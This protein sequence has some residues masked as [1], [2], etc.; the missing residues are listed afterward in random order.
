MIIK[1]YK[2]GMHPNSRNGFQKGH[3]DLV[4]RNLITLSNNSN[5]KVNFNREYWTNYFKVKL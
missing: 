3:P 5:S 4:P 2:R 1:K